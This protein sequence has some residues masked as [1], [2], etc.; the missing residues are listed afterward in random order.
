[1]LTLV[2]FDR[3]KAIAS[4]DAGKRVIRVWLDVID[5]HLNKRLNEQNESA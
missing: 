3:T 4:L 2:E 1:M 5:Q